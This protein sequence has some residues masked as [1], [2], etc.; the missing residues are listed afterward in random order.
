MQKN[1]KN[2]WEL[3]SCASRYS[4]DYETRYSTNELELLAIVWAVEN[5]RNYV[6]GEKFEVISDHKALETALKSNHGNKTYS[7][8]LTRWIDRLLLFDMEVFHQPGRTMGLADYLSR[9]PRDYN[10]NEW[11]KSSKELWESW[12][13]V[14]SVENVNENHERQL[15]ANQRLNN[16]FKQPMIAQDA[17][18]EKEMSETADRPKCESKQIKMSRLQISRERN[19]TRNLIRSSKHQIQI[20]QPKEIEKSSELKTSQLQSTLSSVEEASTSAKINPEITFVK[21]KTFEKLPTCYLWQ[22]IGQIE[23]YKTFGRACYGVTLIYFEK[24]T[25]CSDMCLKI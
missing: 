24:K 3:L 17:E 14:N 15:R 25:N 6:Y 13:V 19:A 18:S 21:V 10:K 11:S 1:E 20:V 4:S 23:G 9:H 5:F 16:L 2:E 22:L 7:S 8:R 12:F